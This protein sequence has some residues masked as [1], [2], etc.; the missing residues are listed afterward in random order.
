M[1]GSPDKILEHL[2]ETRLG[3]TEDLNGEHSSYQGL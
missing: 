2:L 3:K 1:A